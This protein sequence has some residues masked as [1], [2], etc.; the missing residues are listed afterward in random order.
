MPMLTLAALAFAQVA[1]L[2]T[3][4]LCIPDERSQIEATIGFVR[5]DGRVW[6]SPR[7]F[8]DLPRRLFV[9]REFA[10]ARDRPWY[11]ARQSLTIDGR[12]FAYAEP[13]QVTVAFNR[14]HRDHAPVEGVAAAVPQGQ[15]GEVVLILTDPIGCWFAEYRAEPQSQPPSGPSA[16]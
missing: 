15:E 9:S 11:A 13:H 4:H 2:E 3:V 8:P 6:W 5:A 1:D 14:Y 10:S 16:S 7:G 12:R